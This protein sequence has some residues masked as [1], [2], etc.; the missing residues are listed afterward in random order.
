MHGGVHLS[1]CNKIWG[2][3]KKI[4]LHL[5][6][7]LVMEY[8]A[9][10]H[11]N[12]YT[13]RLKLWY[14]CNIKFSFLNRSKIKS[15][16]N[17]CIKDPCK[18]FHALVEELNL[19]AFFSHSTKSESTTH[20]IVLT[21][22]PSTIHEDMMTDGDDNDSNNI[23]QWPAFIFLLPKFL[24]IQDFIYFWN[25]PYRHMQTTIA[26]SKWSRGRQDDDEE[27]TITRNKFFVADL[28][29]PQTIL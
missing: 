25:R 5:H 23:M 6:I 13:T 24:C 21:T 16:P 8:I 7:I 29:S 3:S 26:F 2:G 28:A 1:E 14:Y 11:G 10:Y 15:F 27:K 9:Q 20:A 4:L 17:S 19:L 18:K 12:S 22:S